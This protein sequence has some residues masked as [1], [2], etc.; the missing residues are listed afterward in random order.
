[1]Q[2]KGS[3]LLFISNSNDIAVNIGS[4]GE[5]F[6]PE[7][8]YVYVGSALG[9]GG[10]NKRLARH[11]QK[12]KKLFWH[13]DYLLASKT[14]QVIAILEVVSNRRLECLLSQQLLTSFSRELLVVYEHFGSSDCRCVGHFFFLKALSMEMVVNTLEPFIQSFDAKCRFYNTTT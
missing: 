12:N 11:L 1:M 6:F 2:P 9:P 8:F 10:L 4:L 5:L 14:V 13:I 3:Y 7:G